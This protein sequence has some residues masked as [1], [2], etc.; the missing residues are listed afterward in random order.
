M[1]L[2]KNQILKQLIELEKDW[3]SKK[4]EQFFNYIFGYNE[5][6]KPNIVDGEILYKAI[7]LSKKRKNRNNDKVI[8]ER[9]FKNAE[10]RYS[11]IIKSL[12]VEIPSAKYFM[13]S[14]ESNKLAYCGETPKHEI[15]LDKY[16]I[17]RIPITRKMYKMFNPYIDVKS[18]NQPITDITWFDAYIFALWIG[19]RLPTESEWEFASGKNNDN[20]WCCNEND[21]IN[22]GWYSENSEGIIHDVGL[23]KPNQLGIYDMHGNIWEWVLDFYDDQYYENSDKLNPV[24]LKDNGLHVCRGGSIQGFSEMCRCSFR[25]YEPSDYKASDLGFRVVKEI[26]R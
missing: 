6:N 11:Q 1:K 7:V 26:K 12:M 9:I 20:D 16:K 25:Y 13:G 21:L 15:L 3:D 19:C 22:Y 14:D 24:N 8:N 17:S 23:L 2:T 10:I 18:D 5:L 4:S